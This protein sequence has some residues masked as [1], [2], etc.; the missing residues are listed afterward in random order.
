MSQLTEQ[1]KK[2]SGLLDAVQAVTNRQAF[3]TLLMTF[4]VY[5]VFFV[6]I[7]ALA[8]NFMSNG[9]SALAGITTVVGFLIA[10][11]FALIG[12][13]TAGVIVNDMTRG[14]DSRGIKG[15]LLFALSTIHRPLGVL[16]LAAVFSIVLFLAISLLLLICKIPFAGPV[17]Y[18]VIFPLSVVVTGV[19][20]YAM[21]FVLALTGPAIWEGNTIMRTV[22]LLWAITRNRIFSVIVQ[23]VLLGLLAG[24]AGG[25]I[26]GAVALG[27]AVTGGLSFGMGV[28]HGVAAGFGMAVVFGCALVAPS[29]VV[30]AG[31][32]II[33]ANVTEDLSAEDAENAIKGAINAAKEKAEQ[34]KR[35]LEEKRE[36]PAAE[37]PESPE[38][39][40]PP[41]T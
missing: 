37:T 30:L 16:L 9:Y 3:L 36:Q 12:V 34:A 40:T 10:G 22:A 13:S 11:V 32:C 38:A 15:A 19:T 14:R 26:F 29:L 18:A 39:P 2:S 28:G 27:L 23:T 8:G 4:V 24:L 41:A 25:L 20:L 21:L 33:Y 6:T 35:K 17:L 7:G 1:I 31:N 5:G